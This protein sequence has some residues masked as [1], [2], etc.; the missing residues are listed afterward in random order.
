MQS[1]QAG[2][3]HTLRTVESAL[4]IFTSLLST[5]LRWEDNIKA[6]LKT[7]AEMYFLQ[8]FMLTVAHLCILSSQKLRFVVCFLLL[9][10]IY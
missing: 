4:S 9:M 3:E 10:L 6:I 1:N 5:D 7:A 2:A 8:Q